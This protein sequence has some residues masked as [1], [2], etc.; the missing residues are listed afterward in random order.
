MYQGVS[1]SFRTESTNNYSKHSFRSYTKGYSGK[2]H[3]T[4]LQN[5]NTTAHSGRVLYHLQ[6]SLQGTSPETFGN[7]FVCMYVLC[8]FVCV[9]VCGGGRRMRVYC[10]LNG[11][12]MIC[13]WKDESRPV[14]RE[15][16]LQ[17]LAVAK[18]IFTAA[19]STT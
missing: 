7:T 16:R 2:T 18:L 19:C 1:E 15:A 8:V 14:C 4:D 5:S 10:Q 17:R 12:Y 11:I 9:Y 3:Y 13:L 6:F